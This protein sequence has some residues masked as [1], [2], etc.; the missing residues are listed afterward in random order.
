MAKMLDGSRSNFQSYNGYMFDEFKQMFELTSEVAQD[1]QE[2]KVL[3]ANTQKTTA[4]YNRFT[5]LTMK[6]SDYFFTAEDWN[7]LCDCMINLEK[8]YK[9]KGL[10]QIESTVEDYI[11][12]EDKLNQAINE[13]VG[14][15]IDGMLL[16]NATQIIIDDGYPEPP[17]V[18]NGAVW[19]KPKT[20]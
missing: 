10:D 19:F 12:N 6:L 15:T 4:E 16:T 5:E 11:T 14:D 9:D 3:K 13:K 8:L 7:L 17:A 1:A 2:W 20:N 18:V